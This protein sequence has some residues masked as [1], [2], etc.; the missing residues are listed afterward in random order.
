MKKLILFITIILIFVA[1]ILYITYG[2][3]YLSAI[4]EKKVYKIKGEETTKIDTLDEFM[5]FD[6]GIIS[7]NNHKIVYMDYN[8]KILWNSENTE[9]SNKV[10]VTDNNIFKQ[11][12]NNTIMLDKNNQQLIIDEIKGNIV[13]VSRENEKTAIIVSG[14]G[15]SLFILNE[16]N[17]TVVDNK[18]FKDIITG[19]SISD[20]SE[21]YSLITLKFEEGAPI[22]TLF[23]NLID[24]VE[25]WS[26]KIE[27]EFLI[28]TQVINNNVIAIGTENIYFFNNNGKLMW[29][30]NI[31]NKILDYEISK[32]NQ[33]I[34]ML[35]DNKNNV[36]LISYNFEGKIMEIQE[37]PPNVTSL[38]V[39][40]NRVLTYNNNSIYLL[41]SKKAD[42]IFEDTVS[43]NDF[44]IEG[45]NIY[46]LFKE[47]LIKGQI[48]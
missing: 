29:K 28:K 15:Q 9:F 23:F 16:N 2:K 37:L 35:Y 18:E 48:K 13:N 43:F 14:N 39:F 24:N 41:H 45:N 47:K 36:E 33:R 3:E 10:F 6:K 1:G 44:K 34:Y 19:I 32:E 40:D 25:L 8:N 20:K 5:F 11:T 22:N 46:I 21:S 30:N 42:K 26:T 4:D 12:N 31:Y 27:K 38:K 17:Q 7:Y